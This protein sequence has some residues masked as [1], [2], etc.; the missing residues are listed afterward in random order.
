MGVGLVVGD[1]VAV[2]VG[3]GVGVGEN[4]G[5]GVGVGVLAEVGFAA[6]FLI[7]TPLFQTNLLPCLMQVYLILETT[8]VAPALVHLVDEIETA[9]AGIKN[10]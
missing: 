2:G 5:V 7:A 3:V 4:D 1:V 8:L 10:I 9:L 6:G